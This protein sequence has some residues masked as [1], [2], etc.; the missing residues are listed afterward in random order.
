MIGDAV[1]ADHMALTT[2]TPT[3][4][5]KLLEDRR[6]KRLVSNPK[7]GA[8]WP[9][10]DDG[11]AWFKAL[12]REERLAEG[13]DLATE[14]VYA[15]RAKFEGIP[16]RITRHPPGLTNILKWEAQRKRGLLPDCLTL[17]EYNSQLSFRE[18][19]ASRL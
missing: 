12:Q 5:V 1:D 3:Q 10:R 16:L 6:G 18:R 9:S 15:W 17:E 7:E 11:R 14:D 19:Y 8:K 13:G 2:G 4:R